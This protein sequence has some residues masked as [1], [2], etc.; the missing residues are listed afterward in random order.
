MPESFYQIRMEAA[1]N[2]GSPFDALYSL[3]THFRDEGMAQRDMYQLFM[4]YFREHNDDVEPNVK[5]DALADVMDFIVGWCGPDH[6][7]FEEHLNPQQ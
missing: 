7:L 6:K 3:A 2:V 1:L 4:E 5:R